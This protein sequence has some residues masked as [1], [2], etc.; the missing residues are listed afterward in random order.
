MCMLVRVKI[1]MIIVPLIKLLLREINV[2]QSLRICTQP[3]LVTSYEN[4]QLLAH[5]VVE[6]R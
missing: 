3:V 4:S 1:A 6:Y 5:P 2:S